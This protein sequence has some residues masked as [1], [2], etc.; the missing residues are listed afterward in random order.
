MT[1]YRVTSFPMSFS[2]YVT[3]LAYIG[4]AF[5]MGFLVQLSWIMQ[6]LTR[7]RLNWSIAWSFSLASPQIQPK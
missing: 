6:Q 1:A 7:F 5:E 2:D 3:I 4:I